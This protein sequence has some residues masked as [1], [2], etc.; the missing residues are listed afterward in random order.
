MPNLHSNIP[1][2]APSHALNIGVAT[3]S[4][5]L[6]L[7][8]GKGAIHGFMIVSYIP[9]LA[10]LGTAL[11]SIRKTLISHHI[12]GENHERYNNSDS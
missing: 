9:A 1:K 2:A 4:V 6:R 8:S 10:N 3:S 12:T 5:R 7:S 11:V